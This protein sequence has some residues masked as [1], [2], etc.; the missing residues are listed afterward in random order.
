MSTTN[1]KSCDEN[2]S[3]NK[4]ISDDEINDA[5]EKLAKTKKVKLADDDTYAF[6]LSQCKSCDFYEYGSTC[7]KCGCIVQI[8]ARLLD[9]HCPYSK[10]RKW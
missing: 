10:K 4:V 7:I 1:C 5:I 9:M 6:R 2:K 3:V 8:R